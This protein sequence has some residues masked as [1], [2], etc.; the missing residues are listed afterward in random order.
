MVSKVLVCAL[1]VLCGG[2]IF[3]ACGEKQD[4]DV[5]KINVGRID[6][7]IYDG[8]NHAVQVNY[9]GANANV[10]Y[11]LEENKNVF[12]PLNQLPTR[13]IGTYN[14]YYKLSAK[15]YNDYVSSGTIEFTVVPR[16]LEI[17]LDDYVWIKNNS[18]ED[19][20]I[21][22]MMVGLV[23]G[24]NV[25][26]EYNIHE[27]NRASAQFGD[28]HNIEFAIANSNY[29]LEYNTKTLTVKNF[30]DL[31]DAEGNVVGYYSNIQEALNEA[32]NGQRIVLNKDLSINKTIN[33]NK[34]ITIDG[35]GK[36]SLIAAK[37][38]IS[39]TYAGQPT[40]SIFNVTSNVDFKLKNITLNGAQ[41]VRGVSA[42]A[43]NVEIDNATITNGKKTDKW[44]SG[45]VYIT[46]KASFNMTGGTIINNDASDE[47]YTKYCADLW[48]G[49]NAQGLVNSSI[50]GGVVGNVFVNSNS[51]SAT[52]A[53]KFTLNGGT[54]DN[55]YVEYD[56][57]YGAT[58][59]YVTGKINN[60]MVSLLNDGG[61]YYGVYETLTPV[62][63]RTYKGG[64][65]V[66]TE[67]NLKE[68]EK[69]FHFV[70]ED[71]S[72]LDAKLV[73]GNDYVF[74]NCRFTGPVSTSK[75]V[76]IV[77]NGCTFGGADGE[78]NL[79][80]SSVSR[81]VVN[82]CVFNGTTD[83]I[84]L[85]IALINTNC[86]EVKITNCTFNSTSGND[87]DVAV[88]IKLMKTLYTAPGTLKSAFI[89][90]NTFTNT[91]NVIY[92]GDDPKGNNTAANTYSGNFD[93]L[94]AKNLTDLTI[95]NK[96]KDDAYN[97]GLSNVSVTA[98]R[99]YDST[100][101]G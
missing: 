68:S 69:E 11:A 92:I 70:D 9:E 10:T 37:A 72:N 77:F 56:S 31:C 40:S 51:Y 91:N 46:S 74:E 82:E 3:T 33:I 23:N 64:Q 62:E 52:D 87:E 30:V 80:L 84:A 60:L 25:N 71:I 47:E 49:A 35:Q 13:N 41:V 2:L 90:G 50:T 98:G 27:F 89:A 5:S 58:F 19:I 18:E 16:T 34:S 32:E 61:N 54:I 57:N 39:E 48:I 44:R 38:F 20:K 28:V 55:I 81:L 36:F 45:G 95:L 21:P 101:I 17:V 6:E 93:V 99:I 29:N 42:F 73:Y 67:D 78:S 14:V 100:N 88:S 26:L 53:G 22:Y 8:S 96:F 1:F 59:E 85:D 83:G 15:G 7:F 94:V 12:L 4:F 79:E 43:G 86:D 65:L 63:G 66:Y 24:D 76:G 97:K 75:N